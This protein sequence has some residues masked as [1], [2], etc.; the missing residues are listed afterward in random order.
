ML[1]LLGIVKVAVFA[2]AW[3]P[4]MRLIVSFS[5]VFGGYCMNS[6]EWMLL[7]DQDLAIAWGGYCALS[8]ADG[9]GAGR[10]ILPGDG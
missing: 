1:T 8:E 4:A 7:T 6:A 5:R 9:D 3:T 2:E 10:W